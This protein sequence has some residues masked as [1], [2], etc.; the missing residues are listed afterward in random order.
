MAQARWGGWTARTC[1]RPCGPGSCSW[2]ECSR[3][4]RVVARARGPP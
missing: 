1:S 4:A 3:R 2:T